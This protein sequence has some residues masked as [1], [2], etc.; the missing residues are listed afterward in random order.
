M[1]AEGVRRWDDPD[2]TTLNRLLRAIDADLKTRDVGSDPTVNHMVFP[3]MTIGAFT[4]TKVRKRYPNLRGV[5]ISRVVK[6]GDIPV[7]CDAGL[8]RLVLPYHSKMTDV[9]FGNFVQLQ[10]TLQ[11]IEL[12]NCVFVTNISMQLLM[13]TCS[14]L[15]QVR[16][17]KCKWADNHTLKILCGVDRTSMDVCVGEKRARPPSTVPLEHIEITECDLLYSNSIQ[18]LENI[19]DSLEA[20]NLSGCGM[21]DGMSAAYLAVCTTLV[22]IDLECTRIDDASVRVLSNGCKCLKQLGMGSCEGITELALWWLTPKPIV[23]RLLPQ[24]VRVH[25]ERYITETHQSDIMLTQLSIRACKGMNHTLVFPIIDTWPQLVHL[26]C[27]G[28]SGGYSYLDPCKWK[29]SCYGVLRKC[30]LKTTQ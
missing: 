8:R 9:G 13:D 6:H 14:M 12:V 19:A 18:Y 27:G 21:I 7:Q 30:S 20:I 10:T 11:S 23:L 2:I 29:E 25:F 1:H 26:D 22:S 15:R 16:L 4:L 28:I 3:A 24:T 17:L 5:D